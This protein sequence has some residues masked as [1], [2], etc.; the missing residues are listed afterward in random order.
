MNC[1]AAHGEKQSNSV[2]K[3]VLKA[4]PGTPGLLSEQKQEDTPQEGKW[5]NNYHP[6]FLLLMFEIKGRT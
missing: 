4:L 3:T 6:L 2:W 5:E 1:H